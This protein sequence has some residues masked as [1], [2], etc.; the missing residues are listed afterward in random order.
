MIRPPPRSTRTDTLF[1]YTTLFRSNG[2]FSKP[3]CTMPSHPFAVVLGA[4][5]LVGPHLCER[6]SVAGFHGDSVSR[7]PPAGGA[8]MPAGFRWRQLDIRNPGDWRAPADAVILSL[9]PLWLL[10]DALPYLEAARHIIALGTAS[11]F[12]KAA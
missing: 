11:V 3:I 7:R 12:S 5:S 8:A 9:V 10:S 6:L 1:P 4:T 2:D